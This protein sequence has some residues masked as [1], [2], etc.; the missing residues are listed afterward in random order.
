MRVEELAVAGQR[1]SLG[2]L[3][4]LDA[5]RQRHLTMAVMVAEGLA[6]DGDV[7]ELRFTSL[8]HRVLWADADESEQ[9]MIQ[10]FEADDEEDGSKTNLIR[11]ENRRLTWEQWENEPA[12][13]EVLLRDVKKVQF[14]YFDWRDQEWQDSWDS[15]KADGERGRVPNRVRITF[16]LENELGDEVKFVSQSLLMMQEELNLF[17]N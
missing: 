6:I 10:Y 13:V 5:V 17:T 16:V 14:V 15:T 4:N 12:E 8:G 1:D 9:S 2:L 7:D 3:K 11:R